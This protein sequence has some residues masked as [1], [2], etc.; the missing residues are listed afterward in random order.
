MSAWLHAAR[1]RTL[2]L[3][4]ASILMGSFLAASQNSFSWPIFLWAALTTIFLQVLSNFA[5]DYGDSVNGLDTAERTV[6]TRAVQMG[7]ITRQQM[8]NAIGVFGMLSFLSG[9]TLLSI[10]LKGGGLPT[11]L[12]FLGIG[13][14]AI[15]AAITY[16]VGKKPYGYI[17][18]GDLSVL[19]FFGWVGVLGTHYLHTKQIGWALLLPATTCGLFA[20]AVLNINNIRDIEQD[21]KNGKNSIP[22]RLGKHRATIYHWLLLSV[23]LGCSVMYGVLYFDQWQQWAFL[24]TIPLFFSIG[25]GVQKGQTPAQIDPFLKRMALGTLLF[26]LLFGIGSLFNN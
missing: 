19:I 5:N 16:T 12:A 22:V 8:R 3:A 21:K 15:I 13:I 23:G 1:P 26:V 4:L 14:L 24:G 18:L 7:T 25:R 2:P 9:V 6:A 20:V 17:G 11:F 10:A